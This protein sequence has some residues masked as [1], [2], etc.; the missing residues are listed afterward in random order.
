[1][2]ASTAALQ[3]ASR[4]LVPWNRKSLQSAE[5]SCRP[6]LRIYGAWAWAFTFWEEPNVLQER[7]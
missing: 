2:F 6:L 3:Q 5:L 7:I 1:M 4:L